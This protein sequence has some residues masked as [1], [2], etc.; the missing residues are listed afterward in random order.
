MTYLNYLICILKIILYILN[1]IFILFYSYKTKIKIAIMQQIFYCSVW[2]KVRGPEIKLYSIFIL[3]FIRI[4]FKLFGKIH[5]PN[6]A[7]KLCMVIWLVIYLTNYKLDMV[8]IFDLKSLN[9]LYKHYKNSLYF[10]T[11]KLRKH[12]CRYQ[13]RSYYIIYKT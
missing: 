11:L 4:F 1:Y 5:I 9:K 6:N 10:G 7:S 13:H 3:F 12:E 2:T 8:Y